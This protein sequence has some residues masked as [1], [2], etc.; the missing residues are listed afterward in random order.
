MGRALGIQTHDLCVIKN[1]ELQELHQ[2][3]LHHHHNHQLGILK[4]LVCFWFSL[5]HLNRFIREAKVSNP[6]EWIPRHSI[7]SGQRG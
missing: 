3:H 5:I 6:T 4:V 2:H 1:V 7:Q